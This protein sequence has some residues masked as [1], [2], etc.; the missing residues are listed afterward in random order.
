MENDNISPIIH[1]L[2]CALHIPVTRKGIE[3][4]IAKHPQYSS[5][6][7][8]SDVLN[9]WRIPNAAYQLTFEELV[10]AEI[11]IPFIAYLP[12]KGKE[13]ILVNHM[14]QEKVVITNAKGK[15][16]QLSLEE[17]K[18]MYV[19]GS[20]LIAEKEA[21]SGEADYNLKH[22][23]EKLAALRIPFVITGALSIFIGFFSLY[24][25][26]ITAVNW[27]VTFLF[28]LKTTGLATTILLLVQ[29]VDINNP[30][31]QKLC[32]N[33]NHKDCNAILSSNAAKVTEALSWSEVGFFYFAGTWLSLLFSNNN[34][35]TLQM[36][37]I[38]NIMGLP[39]TFYSIY[40]Q[41]RIARQWC[42]FCCTVQVILWL[43]FFTCLPYISHGLQLPSL[44]G[45]ISLY[46]GMF[47]PVMAWVFIK[48]YFLLSK[49][50]QPL[51]QE[52]RRFKYNTD[53]FNKLLHDEVKYALPA[54]EH[55][56]IIGNREAEHIITMVSNPYC[57]PCAKAHKTINEWLAGRDD[58]KL[59]IVFSNQSN[60]NNPQAK[61][62]PHLMAL[63]TNRDDVS[64]KHA[65]NDW[66][67]Q[68]QKNYD[69]W[70]KLH[71]ADIK[72]KVSKEA[73]D[74]Q[75]EWCKITD[76]KSTPTIFING[77]KLP[78]AYRTE[79]IRYFI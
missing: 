39:Y 68:K 30:L 1:L 17:F 71:P 48:P 37:A 24:L 46:T 23:K 58:I 65:L 11:S 42:K 79:D 27:Q 50:I 72:N 56:I 4:E 53:L 9:Q 18:A 67:E 47:I 12:Q 74:K 38:L 15:K 8:I 64:L 41:W 35:F 77:R 61:V 60:E 52:L 20:V 25:Y 34:P 73:L 44:K 6:L 7:A 70:A 19:E 2:A 78:G 21:D 33:A 63:Q 29:S 62:G 75:K 55:S 14:D 32:S 22:K 13:F 57:Q 31:I 5:M 51:K 66:Y 36:M 69:A 40:Y 45:S 10:T 59:Q 76:I 16:K 26:N 54:E 3:Q 28:F 43:E 49:Q